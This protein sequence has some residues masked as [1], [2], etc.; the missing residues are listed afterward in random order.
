MPPR[1]SGDQLQGREQGRNYYGARILRLTSVARRDWAT[2]RPPDTI[3]VDV[4][5]PVPL[6][7]CVGPSAVGGRPPPDARPRRR[8]ERGGSARLCLRVSA[9]RAPL[10]PGARRGPRLRRLRRSPNGSLSR[11][12]CEHRDLL[13][14]STDDPGPM[15]YEHT[16]HF[17]ASDPE[18][19][20]ATATARPRVGSARG[21]STLKQHSFI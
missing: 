13:A 20:R 4:S 8:G 15:D 18:G 2:R 3:S 12:S 5:A 16:V 10:R 19:T 9:S 14:S 21:H 6:D 11:R 7:R 1:S 17:V